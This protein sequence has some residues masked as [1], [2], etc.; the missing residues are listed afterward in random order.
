MPVQAAVGGLPHASGD[1]TEIVRVVLAHYGR[2][3]DHASAAERAEQA[4]VECLPRIFR[5]GVFLLSSCA[6]GRSS[7]LLRRRLLGLRGRIGFFLLSESRSDYR[8]KEKD[9]GDCTQ[10]LHLQGLASGKES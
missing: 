4:I 5:F 9:Q 8:R 1:C 10:S 2:N 7:L 3:S 6:N